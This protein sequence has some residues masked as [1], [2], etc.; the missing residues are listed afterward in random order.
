MHC[1]LLLL[2]S[3]VYIF[4]NDI[5]ICHL[6]HGKNS[7]ITGIFLDAR[8]I[9]QHGQA[10]SEIFDRYLNGFDEA[11]FSYP[12]LIFSEKKSPAD[13]QNGSNEDD[14]DKT[15]VAAKFLNSAVLADCFP[16]MQLAFEDRRALFKDGD[17]LAA[18]VI[19]CIAAN[20]GT[21]AWDQPEVR[22]LI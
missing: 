15:Q 1:F 22:S 4:R 18:Q 9:G 17:E 19:D 14:T 12:N 20:T 5:G 3:V 6:S 8:T 7:C 16:L 10:C 11:V 21:V 13:N 2:A